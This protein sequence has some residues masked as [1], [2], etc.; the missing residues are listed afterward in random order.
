MN[1]LYTPVVLTALFWIAIFL[2][3]KLVLKIL[4]R[5]T[6]KSTAD[7][8]DVTVGILHNPILI[9]ILTEGLYG[10]LVAMHPQAEYLS[11]IATARRL[12]HLILILWITWR[13]IYQEYIKYYLR[14]WADKTEGNVDNILIPIIEVTFPLVFFIVSPILILQAIGVNTSG[15]GIILGG[16]SFVLAFA[17]QGILA[18]IFAGIALLVDSPFGK[19]DILQIGDD[20]MEVKKIGMRVTELYKFENHATLFVANSKLAQEDI[21]NLTYPT[22]DIREHL[23]IGV[24]YGVNA[25]VVENILIEVLNT[26]PYILGN[27]KLKIQLMKKRLKELEH[28]NRDGLYDEDI[29]ILKWG[30]SKWALENQL[31]QKIGE[32]KSRI[33]KLVKFISKHEKDGID[34]QELS[35]IKDRV[36]SGFDGSIQE[37]TKTMLKWKKAILKDPNLFPSDIPT[38]NN[39]WNIKIKR[40]EQHWK[41]LLAFLE[42]AGTADLQRI[43]TRLE[44]F[45][46]WITEKFKEVYEPWKD[47]DA[48]LV[49]FGDSAIIFECEFFV[50][51]IK[52]ERYERLGRVKADIKREIYEK[53]NEHN[54]E[55]PFPQNDMWFRNRL[56]VVV[57]NREEQNAN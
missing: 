13:L 25:R 48:E 8:D 36:S 38:L 19:G 9:A 41:K 17:L 39:Y 16:A 52:S 37:L 24:A 45:L 20:L 34:Q 15:W 44:N 18:D 47:P 7:L 56:E 11:Y 40:L 51:D 23:E 2:I 4:L 49:E 30:V 42:K 55:I 57:K 31:Y 32:L 29:Q 50:D 14:K 10:T 28:K 43:D 5:I 12:I 53:L 26:N 21:I 3:A 54:I 46:S 35:Y 33:K 22:A 1:L 27:P 6:E